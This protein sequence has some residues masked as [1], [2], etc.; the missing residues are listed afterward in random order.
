[1]IILARGRSKRSKG[2]GRSKANKR[3]TWKQI[4]EKV[5]AGKELTK[6]EREFMSR[7]LDRRRRAKNEGRR[8][9]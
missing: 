5:R 3:I 6:R 1:M 4:M 7:S 8:R 9:R 2:R